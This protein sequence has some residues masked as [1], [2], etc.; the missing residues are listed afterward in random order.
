MK[1][2]TY[3]DMRLFRCLD[4]AQN[5]RQT[6]ISYYL[7]IPKD[8]QAYFFKANASKY[9]ELSRHRVPTLF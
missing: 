3:L 5:N 4:L 7:T 8:N 1:T 2:V 9:F 6:V